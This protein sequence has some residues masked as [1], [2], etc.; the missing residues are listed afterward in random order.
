MLGDIAPARIER[1]LA[2][3]MKI[4]F[5][6]SAPTLPARQSS[7]TAA[8]GTVAHRALE[9]YFSQA[10]ETIDLAWSEAVNEMKSAKS[11]DVEGYPGARRTLLRLQRRLPELLR[12]VEEDAADQ[13][14]LEQSLSVPDVSLR[15]TPD[16]VLIGDGITV[17]DYKTGLV[18]AEDVVFA[19]YAQ[20]LAIYAWLAAR[21]FDRE[22]VRGAL[23]SLRRGI[24]Q[25]DVSKAVR[26]VVTAKALAARDAYNDRVPGPQPATPSESACTWCSFV[27]YCPAPW[28]AFQSGQLE[29]LGSGQAVRGVVNH[30]EATSG[31]GPVAVSLQCDAGTVVGTVTIIDVPAE[32]AQGVSAGQEAAF[33]G[34]GLRSESPV[35]LRW[36]DGSSRAGSSLPG[37]SDELP[38]GPAKT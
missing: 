22:K 19:R 28:S 24:V 23:F 16:M 5:E 7:P 36:W 34:L 1:L 32:T 30:V 10:T 25:V 35:V 18:D 4:A 11:I 9:L 8:L 3:P 29:S 17:V 31:G 13:T 15:G 14:L 38:S 21:T 20:Q 33:V 26:E 37:V 27:C 12:Y 2:C 6:Q